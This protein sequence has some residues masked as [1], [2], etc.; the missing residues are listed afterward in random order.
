MIHD[1]DGNPLYEETKI[2]AQKH[3]KSQADYIIKYIESTGLPF[4][5]INQSGYQYRIYLNSGK[6]LDVWCSTTKHTIVGTNKYGK[7]L[8]N[9]KKIINN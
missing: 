2:N 4:D 7:G 5:I 8:A 9:I 3:R 6:K 1:S